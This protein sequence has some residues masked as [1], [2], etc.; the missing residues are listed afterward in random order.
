MD[1]ERAAR[2]LNMEL[3]GLGPEDFLDPDEQEAVDGPVL[4]LPDCEYWA[5]QDLPAN[6]PT[7]AEAELGEYVLTIRFDAQTPL[8]AQLVASDVLVRLRK[9]TATN[10]SAELT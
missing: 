8:E 6:W 7:D 2:I 10:I 3:L 4:N 5:T 1:F 9:T